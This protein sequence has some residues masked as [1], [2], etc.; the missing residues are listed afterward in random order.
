METLFKQRE[1][2]LSGEAP[3]FD[4]CHGGWWIE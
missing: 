2:G 4:A 3:P 1:E